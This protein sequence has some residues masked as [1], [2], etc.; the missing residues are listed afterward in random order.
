MSLGHRNPQGLIF[1]EDK[2]L[3]IN[4]E[5]GPKGGDEINLNFIGDSKEIVNVKKSN[6]YT[7]KL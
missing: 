3:I 7:D 6:N 2:N 4:S 5:H 1:I